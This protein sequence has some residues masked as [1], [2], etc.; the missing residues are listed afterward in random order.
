MIP[1][2]TLLL[3]D[4]IT[5]GLKS[6]VSADGGV[7]DIA[8]G[9]QT[10]DWLLGQVRAAEQRG[11]LSDVSNAVVLIGTNDVGGPA[12]VDHI[13]Q[14]IHKI[15]TILGQAG[16]RVFAMTIPPFNGWQTYAPS[17]DV[18][19]H[20]VNDA[21]RA[22][23][24]RG[25]RYSSEFVVGVVD[26]ARLL[27]DP[28]D[29]DKLAREHDSGDHLH[30]RKDRLG[31]LITTEVER[32]MSEKAHRA[33]TRATLSAAAGVAALGLATWLGYHLWKSRY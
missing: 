8:K 21:L 6:Y 30:P 10:S 22:F 23:D 15:W 24:V 13:L 19:R 3:G 14:N 5:V 4:S 32:I 12:T 2:T 1:G 27:A 28:S 25:T 33:R 29:P 17:W 7:R 16:A 9:G 20:A 31:S 18:K 26:L 11:E